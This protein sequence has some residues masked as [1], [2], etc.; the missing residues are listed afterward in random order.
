MRECVNCREAW[1]FDTETIATLFGL[2]S[3]F[4]TTLLFEDAFELGQ[5]HLLIA[6]QQNDQVLLAIG[7]SEVGV[8]HQFTGDFSISRS[9]FNKSIEL[10]LEDRYATEQ[11]TSVLILDPL[12]H[13][14][15]HLALTQ[16]ALGFPDQATQT[17]EKARVWIEAFQ[18]PFHMTHYYGFAG[19]LYQ[20]MGNIDRLS[21]LSLLHQQIS[22]ENA[23]GL[24][25]AWVDM[26][27]GWVL[28]EQGSYLEGLEMLQNGFAVWTGVGMRAMV[29]Y[30]QSLI[31]P[32]YG[33]LGEYETGLALLDEAL[34]LIEETHHRFFESDIHRLQ[35]ELRWMQSASSKEVAGHFRK[36]LD[37]ARKQEAKSY[38]LRAAMSL[39]RLWHS[40]GKENEA[41]E[42][43]AGVY[44][45]FTEGF[46]TRDLIDAKRLLDEWS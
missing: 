2:Y 32:I 36:S 37:V 22:E 43:L 7:H 13:A 44:D 1:S 25:L 45:W 10:F 20:F 33:K 30:W 28:S 41:R 27:K 46:G 29:P 40:Q 5:E 39:G 4:M 6:E 24:N 12:G 15:D 17:I 19:F 16:W 9:H 26:Q 31:A 14:W 21:Q 42:L 23:F 8:A 35:G 38:E 3:Y 11:L 34:E 18:N